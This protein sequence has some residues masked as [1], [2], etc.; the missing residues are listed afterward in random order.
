[1]CPDV[2]PCRLGFRGCPGTIGGGGA[3]RPALLVNE[4]EMKECSGTTLTAFWTHAC[5]L[6]L[7]SASH[8]HGAVASGSNLE[9]ADFCQVLTCEISHMSDISNTPWLRCGDQ[10]SPMQDSYRCSCSAR[11]AEDGGQQRRYRC[12]EHRSFLGMMHSG[13]LLL[14]FLAE[15]RGKR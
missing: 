1:M 12:K 6:P 5:S 13:D 11:Q 4:V 15:T 10:L 14:A 3:L 8:F 9:A 2:G 7:S